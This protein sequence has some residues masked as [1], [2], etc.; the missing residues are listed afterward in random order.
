MSDWSE[1]SKQKLKLCIG[2]VIYLIEDKKSPINNRQLFR[3]CEKFVGF[4]QFAEKTEAGG[5][6]AMEMI[7]R[8]LKA[9]GGY[10]CGNLSYGVDPES[11]LAVEYREVIHRLSERQHEMYNNM[12]RVWQ[13]VLKNFNR[14]LDITN[15]SCVSRRYIAGQFR[16]EYQRCFRNLI[17]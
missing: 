14:A 17:I 16:A 7:T 10:F 8:D 9:M 5:I 12:A 11:G 2:E 4:A 13:E 15:S 6:R 1:K 3:I